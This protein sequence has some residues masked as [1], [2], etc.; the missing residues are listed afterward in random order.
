MAIKRRIESS[1]VLFDVLYVDGTRSSNRRVATT[2]LMGLDGDEPAI[3]I[4]EQ[5]DREISAASGRPRPAV[6]A[7]TRAPIKPSVKVT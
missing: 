5:Q 3:A 2:A 7:L 6:K 1:F 4:I